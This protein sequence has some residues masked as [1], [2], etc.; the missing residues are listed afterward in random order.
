M[1]GWRGGD[2]AGDAGHVADV[3]QARPA[4]SMS[5]LLVVGPT[6][7]A[8]QARLH[9]VAEQGAHVVGESVLSTTT[10]ARLVGGGA[11]QEPGP[12]LQPPTPL[13]VITRDA[14][15][16]MRVGDA[17]AW[18]SFTSSTTPYL[19]LAQCGSGQG[20]KALAVRDTHPGARIAE[21]ITSRRAGALGGRVLAPGPRLS[22]KPS[23]W[24]WWRARSRRRHA[25]LFRDEVKPSLP[26]PAGGAYN[27][28]F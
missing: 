24:W 20:G 19:S 12:V 4:A 13:T 2:R 27:R 6:A 3:E 9:L 14:R 21:V 5:D 22:N 25:R 23:W 16:R 26:A 1:W 10:T 11:D 8:G 7:G 18:Y 15:P 28:R 17:R